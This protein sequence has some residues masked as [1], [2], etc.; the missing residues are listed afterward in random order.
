MLGL[1]RALLKRVMIG[2]LLL[3]CRGRRVLET[4]EAFLA[5]CVVGLLPLDLL[6]SL[7]RGSAT[8]GSAS[9]IKPKAS[10]IKVIL[11]LC[12]CFLINIIKFL[13]SATLLCRQLKLPVILPYSGY[14][15]A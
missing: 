9:S 13:S 10:V 4:A 14:F 5:C 7:R 3:M 12:L 8:M 15:S 11:K 2:A 1:I 6:L